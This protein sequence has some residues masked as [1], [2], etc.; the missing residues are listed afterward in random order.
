MHEIER[1]LFHL[2]LR[3]SS[4]Y[5]LKTQL[6]NSAQL[7]KEIHFSVKQVLCALHEMKTISHSHIIHNF[8]RNT[9]FFSFDLNSLH[10]SLSLSRCFALLCAA[11][12]WSR[13]ESRRWKIIE[14]IYSVCN[15]FRHFYFISLTRSF[16]AAARWNLIFFSQYWQLRVIVIVFALALTMYLVY[17]V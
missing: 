1:A 8:I 5:S 15:I 4:L 2:L 7:T 14:L 6:S 16:A 11:L 17:L 3:H 13:S 9:F 10:F 12:C